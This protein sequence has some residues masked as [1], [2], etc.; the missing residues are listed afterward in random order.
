MRAAELG[1]IQNLLQVYMFYNNKRVMLDFID[2]HE[3]CY[4]SQSRRTFFTEVIRVEAL[5]VLE[6][7][8]QH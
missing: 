4:A 6:I 8:W 1:S 3:Q 5:G 7:K 2:I